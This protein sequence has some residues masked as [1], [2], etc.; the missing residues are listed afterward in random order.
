[1]I[2]LITIIHVLLCIGLCLVILLQ[3]GKGMVMIH[4]NISLTSDNFKNPCAVPKRPRDP[5]R[6]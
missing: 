3:A 5:P 6:G 4:H 1:M 2:T